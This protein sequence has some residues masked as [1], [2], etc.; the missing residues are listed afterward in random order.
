MRNQPQPLTPEECMRV[1]TLT[2][3]LQRA[4]AENRP[5]LLQYVKRNGERS[6]STGTVEFF[7]GSPRM[8]TGSVTLKTED[9]GM[10]TINLCRVVNMR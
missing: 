10:R 5:V 7:N 6:Q 1:N 2:V 4:Q 3:H 9:K 8:D